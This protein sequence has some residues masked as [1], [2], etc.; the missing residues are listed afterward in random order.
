MNVYIFVY[1]HKNV[2]ESLHQKPLT[3]AVCEEVPGL[4]EEKGGKENFQCISFLYL[5]FEP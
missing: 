2:P 1:V 5:H 3:W 4:L